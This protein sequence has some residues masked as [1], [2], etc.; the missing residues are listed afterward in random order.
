MRPF[1][2]G[3]LLKQGFRNKMESSNSVQVGGF[4]SVCVQPLFC[5]RHKPWQLPRNRVGVF[6]AGFHR[7]LLSFVEMFTWPWSAFTMAM[8]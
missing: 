6:Y 3:Q 5:L 7:A 2:W 8:L 1:I 4:V